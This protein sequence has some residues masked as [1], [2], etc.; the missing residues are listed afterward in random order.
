[1]REWG[2]LTHKK[3]R[4]PLAAERSPRGE[5][6]GFD[7]SVPAKAPDPERW[8]YPESDWGLLA[9]LK[10]QQPVYDV[11]LQRERDAPQMAIERERTKAE[12]QAKIQAVIR[13]QK[14]KLAQER[15]ESI[16]QEKLMREREEMMENPQK[17]HE[18]Q[19]R[20]AAK[21]ASSA[22]AIDSSIFGLDESD[23]P[24][25]TQSKSGQP[26]RRSHVPLDHLLDPNHDKTDHSSLDAVAR[27][28]KQNL[29][30]IKDELRAKEHLLDF[31]VSTIKEIQDKVPQV[32]K[33]YR[34]DRAAQF[35]AKQGEKALKAPPKPYASNF[36]ETVPPFRP[37]GIL[38][39]S[40]KE[41][42]AQ[43]KKVAAAKAAYGA[44]QTTSSSSGLSLDTLHHELKKT[45]DMISRQ[46]LTLALKTKPPKHYEMK[47]VP[48]ESKRRSAEHHNNNDH[49][50]DA[51]EDDVI[52][53]KP[54]SSSSSASRFQ[55]SGRATLQGRK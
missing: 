10:S 9:K 21:S 26:H 12:N 5:F 36:Y 39:A 42:Q 3:Q 25:R 50:G 45:E 35:I 38:I 24:P 34:A 51:D 22:V 2:L 18:K 54:L 16:A 46:K 15:A 49:E 30:K 14:A 44:T 43:N 53:R 29:R 20:L 32:L 33:E 27:S 48:R 19:L 13:E 37:G 31:K 28:T 1:M 8:Q 40:T 52:L 6:A 11:L 4:N 7:F 47:N 55:S 41:L 23:E 17:Y